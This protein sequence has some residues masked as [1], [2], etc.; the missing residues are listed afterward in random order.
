MEALF[1]L[2]LL[3]IGSLLLPFIFVFIHS[4]Q[5]RTMR[6]ILENLSSRIRQLEVERGS[7]PQ[8][9]PSPSS[10]PSPPAAVP[11]MSAVSATVAPP[12]VPTAQPPPMPAAAKEQTAGT[13]PPPLPRPPAPVPTAA[14]NWE[15]FM[16]IKLFAWLGG[17]ALFLGIVFFIKYAFENNLVGPTARIVIG[18]VAGVAL[19]ATGLVTA[20]RNYRVPA[21]SLCATGVLVLY[22]VIFAA[23]EFYNLISLPAAYVMMVAVTIGAFV[24]AVRLDARVI[25]VLGLLGGFLTPI[26]LNTGRDNAPALFGYIALLNAGV[27]AIALRKRWEFLIVL[28]ALGTIL[29]QFGWA[30]KFFSANPAIVPALICLGFQGLFLIIALASRDPARERSGVFSAAALGIV[31]LL[32][33]WK[34]NS[35]PQIARSPGLFFAWLF[36]A[37][38]GLQVLSILRARVA[39]VAEVAASIAFAILAAWTTRWMEQP[40][41]PWAI[42]ACLVFA[43][44]HAGIFQ[45]P[46]QIDRTRSPAAWIRGATMMLVAFVVLAQGHAT[47]TVAASFII[48]LVIT[49]AMTLVR[50]TTFALAAAGALVFVL[51]VT[52]EWMSSRKLSLSRMQHFAGTFSGLTVFLLP[53]LVFLGR[54]MRDI[55]RADARIGI[56]NSPLAVAMPFVLLVILVAK[57]LPLGPTPV[58]ATL[59]ALNVLLLGAS[60]WHRASWIAA[61]ALTASWPVQCAWQAIHFTADSGFLPLT[62][63]VAILLLFVAYPFFVQIKDEALPWAISAVA[64]VMQFWLVYQEVIAT[65]PNSAMGLLP[66]IFIIPCAVSILYLARAKNV[67]LAKGDARIAWQGG[68]AILFVSLI[69]PIQFEREWITLG[70]ALVGVGLLLFY[71]FVPNRGLRFVAAALLFLAFAR[72]ALNP[73]VLTYHKRTAVPI[74]NWYLYAY[75]I[76]SACLFFGARLYGEPF[77]NRFERAVP[78]LFYA[79]SGTLL[80]LLLNIEIADYFS[81]GPTLTFSFE[82]NFARDMAYSIAWALFGFGLLILGMVRE[83]KLA[84]YAGLALLGLTLIK[85]FLHDLGSLGQ[86]Y[87]IGAFIGVALVLIIASFVYQRFLSG[88]DAKQN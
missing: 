33:C 10:V 46:R 60:V 29:T 77:A 50:S 5:I 43:L 88:Q 12:P 18:T 51:F 30:G 73:A 45:W 69:F 24:L 47:F 26:L 6:R 81:V 78:R 35:Y 63:H 9:A 14:I 72:L 54:P 79:L 61:I 58:F 23:H 37:D 20:K 8:A 80:F 22:S 62:W 75:G 25:V 86:L 48:V 44:M 68:V 15:A 56:N 83:L 65:Y 70:W 53:A 32:F 16:G 27:A 40:L 67:D 36:L 42:G 2:A 11:S 19:I 52:A 21:L 3:A 64:G 76:T 85:L 74:W 41:L 87:R 4:S 59:F 84:R 57:V 55:V 82:G 28:A 7:A 49:T 1:F 66:A 71:R 38:A 13:I 17:F 34:L 39:L 31:S